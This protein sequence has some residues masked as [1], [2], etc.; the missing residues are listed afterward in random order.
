MI[1]PFK[2]VI[3]DSYKAVEHRLLAAIHV[4]FGLPAA[5]PAELTRMIK[6]A[7]RAAAYL[8]AT[9]LAGFKL[10]EA[11][12]FFG[13]P[14]DVPA[15]FERDYLVPWSAKDAEARYFK[16]ISELQESE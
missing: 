12:R 11:R 13:T 3:G 16:R 15:A 2:A 10:P 8:E 14:P 5:L 6:S 4:R 9:R 7:D 1:T